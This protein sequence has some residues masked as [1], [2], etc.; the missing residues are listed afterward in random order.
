MITLTADQNVAAGSRTK[1]NARILTQGR[2]RFNHIHPLWLSLSLS[3]SLSLP[4]A[5]SLSLALALGC[6]RSLSQP[7]A[8]A[9]AFCQ[10]P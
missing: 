10:P 7:R 9:T 1:E 3:L 2:R 5:L 8:R 6:Q 4:L